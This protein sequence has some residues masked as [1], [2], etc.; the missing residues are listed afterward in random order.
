[1]MVRLPEGI[2]EVL[3]CQRVHQVGASPAS[4]RVLMKKKKE[5]V[6]E[7]GV[8]SESDDL[9]GQSHE[10]FRFLFVSISSIWAHDSPAASFSQMSQNSQS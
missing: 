10:I 7:D 6:R 8:S 1:M 5:R 4:L 9:K 3:R 2:T